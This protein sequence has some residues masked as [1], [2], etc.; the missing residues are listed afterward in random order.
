MSP[1]VSIIIPTFNRAHLLLESLNSIIGQSFDNWECLIVDDGSDYENLKYLKEMANNDVRIHHYSRPYDII[2]GPSG[3]R[4]YGLRK[5][6]GK[7]IQFFDDDDVMY[8]EMI[9]LKVEM[10]LKDNYD[11]VVAQLDY[12]DVSL[13]KII[14]QNKIYSENVIDDYVLGNISWYVSGPLWKKEFLLEEFDLTIQTLDDWDFNLRNIYRKPNITFLNY[15]LQRYNRYALGE[16]LSTLGQIGNDKQIESS[17]LVYKKHYNLLR[18]QNLLNTKL[19]LCLFKRLVFLL[20]ASLEN[21]HDSSKFIYKFLHKNM[22]AI[23]AIK[24]IKIM[25]GYYSYKLFGKGYRFIN[26]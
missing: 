23:D 20:R 2:K 13:N 8:P 14:K 21:N 1:I 4:N 18:N 5:A 11:A 7:Y 6:K 15:P 10:I 24:L 9:K 12:Y 22:R 3:C 25:T 19:H 17:F 16:T 26:F